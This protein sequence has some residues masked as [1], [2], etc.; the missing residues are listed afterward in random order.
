[1]SDLY[2]SLEILGYGF[3]SCCFIGMV[4][5]TSKT[6]KNCYDKYIL[7]LPEPDEPVNI[8]SPFYN[9][10]GR[11]AKA[12]ANIVASEIHIVDITVIIGFTD[13]EEGSKSEIFRRCDAGASNENDSETELETNIIAVEIV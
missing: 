10:A 12:E 7:R 9:L 3:V 6:I 11:Y 5:C 1:M 13:F 4:V 8:N 2:L